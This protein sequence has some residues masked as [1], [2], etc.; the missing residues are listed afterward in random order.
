MK[1][2]ASRLRAAVALLAFAVA[3]TAVL[4][5]H[6]SAQGV[7]TSPESFFGF[8]MGADRKIAR[9]DK[10]VEYFR[11][12]EK[13]SGKMKVI[14]MGP[15]TEGNPFLQVIVTAPTNLARL[16]R[17]REVNARLSDPRGVPEAEIRKLVAEGKAVICQS[18][19]LHATEIGGTQMAPE[20]AYELAT[21]T[22]EETKRILDNVIF[23]MIPS[24]NPDGQIM[25][26]DWYNKW[27]GTEY[28]AAGL[29]WLYHKYAGHDNNRDAFMTNLVESQ[30]LAK[31]MFREWVPQAYI[32]HHHMGSY[33]ARIY[34]PPYAEPIRPYADPL[35]WRE[36]SWYGAH[37]AYK[38]EEAGLSGVV[39]A[40]QYSG[41]G[42]FGFHW[43]TPFHNIA[44]MLTESAS[45][46]LATPLF[47]HPD[48]L[49]GGA[50]GLP[51]YEAQT[52]FPNPWPGGWWRLRDIV[53]RQ[54][55]S[56][57]ATLDLAARNKETVLWNAYLKAKRQ[58][59][60]GAAHKPAAFVIPAAQHDLLTAIKMVN[61]LIAQG[62]EIHQAKAQFSHNGV[63]YPAGSFVV[64]MA[65]PKMGLIRYLLWRTF[66]PDNSYTRDAQGNPIRP[67]DMA[68][69]TMFE[70][71][72]VRVDPV[73][74]MVKADLVE[75]TGEVPA[76]GKVTRAAAGYQLD[77]QLN[78]AFRAVNLL[79]DKGIQVRRV[80]SGPHAGDFIVP[81]GQETVLEAVAKATGVDFA[82]VSVP[83]GERVHDVRRARV[84]MYQ[85]YGGGNMD[86]GWTRLVLE[87]FG[88]PYAS[89]K[90]AELK[91]GNLDAKYDV[92][93]LPSDSVAA[94][95]GERAAAG[96]RGAGEGQTST[97][98]EYRSG[99]GNEGV[100]A[101]QAFVQKGGTL[102]TFAEAGTLPIERFALPVRNVLTGLEPK[103]FFCPGSTLRTRVDN[104]HPLAYGMPERALATFLSGS[105][106]YEFIATERNER[107][108]PIV[109]FVER[110]LLESGWLVGE[111][112]IRKKAT[113]VAVR[114]GEGKVV[115]IGFR[116]QHR[117]QTHGT[118][119]LL[120]N[121]LMGEGRTAKTN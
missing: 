52:T 89:I 96:G 3:A 98:P 57:W 31:L 41:W 107:I 6:P 100:Q 82:P 121:A 34:V 69:D 38:E 78:D 114:H 68:T 71:M 44:G 21:R 23:F 63:M 14:D 110:D 120:F 74:D 20:L 8:R 113:M 42:H 67:Y 73:D 40:A 65:Q 32:D 36:H 53:E 88:F 83:P 75:L 102:V 27:L 59:E 61:K 112:V 2:P 33:G 15:T 92:V 80:E 50:R 90:D 54:K 51:E 49:R 5:A 45:A 106:A 119:K 105:Q 91:Q 86:E 64:S 47:I 70:F 79:I 81:S 37:I 4:S 93:I 18:M 104:T 13:Q 99:F 87:Q 115:L 85:R 9:W 30:Y 111:E 101:L 17:L 43:I 19:S 35:L 116:A 76:A 28:E 66:Y 48:Q 25:V 84:A 108:E 11:L 1:I 117:A 12:L 103:R 46:R 58:T 77:A 109:T 95:T 62:V 55:V 60:R 56:A 72:G 118:Y 7:V 16:D 94:M 97:P 24:F 29:P 22:D 39:N 10:I 26:T